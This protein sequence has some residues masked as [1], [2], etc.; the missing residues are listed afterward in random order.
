MLCSCSVQTG[1]LRPG[2]QPTV[3]LPCLDWLLASC[4]A[5]PQPGRVLLDSFLQKVVF[6]FFFFL[7]AAS[8][9]TLWK[10]EANGPPFW[11][12]INT[13]VNVWQLGA[14]LG[15][16]STFIV[17]RMFHQP[18]ET[19]ISGARL[20]SILILTYNML[21]TCTRVTSLL[22]WFVA[23]LQLR[24]QVGCTHY[25]VS[26]FFKNQRFGAKMQD[27]GSVSVSVVHHFWAIQ[28]WAQVE[29]FENT[30]RVVLQLCWA[31]ALEL[32]SV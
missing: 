16:T 26:N 32:Q 5:W 29:G 10:S 14:G 11:V 31:C 19:S 21:D 18:C 1:R 8:V 7:S 30:A 27:F 20:H 9:N 17:Q 13:S 15:C 24:P 23:V 12:G 4:A 22:F 6:L 3:H 28:K 25:S 2:Q